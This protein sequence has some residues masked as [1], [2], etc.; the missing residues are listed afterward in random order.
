MVTEIG[1]TSAAPE[2]MTTSRE[3]LAKGQ[4]ALEQ[5]DLLQASEKGWGAA[6]HMVK[7]VA[8]K[9]GWPHNGHRELYQIV[10]RL[11]Q[12]TGERRI[13]VLFNS[14][15]ALHSNFYEQ[16]MPREMIEDGLAEIRDFLAR[17]EELK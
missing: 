7:A 16:W 10:N 5:D 15:S 8:E 14:A 9:R 1:M 4:E 12:E 13:R 11:A 6:A 17:L 2:H 3:L